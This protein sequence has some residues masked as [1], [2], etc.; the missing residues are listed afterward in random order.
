MAAVVSVEVLAW[1]RTALQCSR[2]LVPC[3]RVLELVASLDSEGIRLC[4][5]FIKHRGKPCSAASGGK[6][7]I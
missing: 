7:A 4:S 3:V 1:S 2:P 6:A 5:V